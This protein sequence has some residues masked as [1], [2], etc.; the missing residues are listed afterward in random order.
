MNRSDQAVASQERNLRPPEDDAPPPRRLLIGWGT[1][2][3]ALA[4]S[5]AA[6]GFVLW[7][8]RFPIAQFFL[9]SALAERGVEAD[10][11][12]VQ[13]DFG[14]IVLNGVRIGSAQA[15]DASIATVTAAWD[16]RGLAPSVR[17]LR[18]VEP[19]LR[20]R[21]DNRGR[22]S[23]G[24][25]DHV[26]GAPSGHRPQVPELEV[27]VERGVLQVDA[28]FGPLVADVSA[29]GVLG[30]DFSALG[31]L[32][33]ITGARRNY[34]I[35]EGAGSFVVVSR[36]HEIGLRV[37]A[38]AQSLL[39]GD[40]RVSGLALRG[41]V[42]APLDLSRYEL[43][44]AWRVGALNSNALSADA[45]DGG[46]AF[47]A[48]ARDDSLLAS[49]WRARARAGA[50]RLTLGGASFTTARLDGGLDGR[51]MRGQGRWA[52]SGESFQGF[53]LI[54]ERATASGVLAVNLAGAGGADATGVIAMTRARLDPGARRIVDSMLPGLGGTPLAPT[55]A[56]ANAALRRGGANFALTAPF[57]AHFES[58]IQRIVFNRELFAHAASGLRLSVAPLRVDAPG[59][60]LEWPGA[61]LRGAVDVELSGGGA[62]TASMLLDTVHW[63]PGEPLEADGTLALSH[64]TAGDASLSADQLDI[65][66][67]IGTRGQGRIDLRGPAHITGPFGDGEVRDMAPNLDIGIAWDAGW[68]IV[69]NTPCLTVALGGLN[70]AGLS[71]DSG[72]L[73][74]CALNGALA[75]SDARG[76][77]GGGF[78]IQGLALNGRMAGP[79]AQPARLTAAE[80]T[81]R[82]HGAGA[83][84]ELSIEANRPALEINV[85]ADHVLALRGAQVTADAALAHDWRID[86]RF[87]DGALSDPALPG[88]VTAIAG[89]WAAAPEDDKAVIR[90]DAGEALLTANRP[91]SD[92][93]RPLFHQ[94][95]LAGFSAILRDGNIDAQGE[96]VL[97]EQTHQLARFTAHHDVAAGAGGAV[98]TGDSVT[99]DRT[100]QPYQISELARGFVDNVRGSV[101]LNANIDW[102]R[103]SIAAH[104]VL[105]LDGVSLAT[106]TIPVIQGVRGDVAFNNLFSLTT[107]PGQEITIDALNPGLVVHNGR[108]RFQLLPGRRIGI[109]R[110]EFDFASG[111]LS[112]T[113]TIIPIGAEETR[114]ELSL[115]NVDA[116]ALLATLNIPDLSATGK[117]DGA[118]PLLLTRRT[119]LIQNGALY[120]QRGG[121]TISY[122]G[123]A[124]DSATGAARI[125]FDALKS[126][127]YDDLHIA[128]NGDLSG[129][130]VSA[131]QFHGHNSGRPVDLGPIGAVPGL[132]HI[133][134][135]GVPFAFQVQVTA[136]FRSLAETAASLSNPNAI[137]TRA[138]NAEPA[139]QPVDQR[140]QG[141]R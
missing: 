11:Q 119:A 28:P 57:S 105:H 55:F 100:F 49:T 37:D 17:S 67:S 40:A 68:R 109:E 87:R 62:P 70:A 3:A 10:F 59:L 34:A 96:L 15:P 114:F 102:T 129:E 8:A 4:V 27:V 32:R 78:R 39:W 98:V 90:V 26:G 133:T 38:N 9:S 108:V 29:H 137:L 92:A 82:F 126:F 123:H 132:G 106:S 5:T 64:W 23:A 61:S 69:S 58:G 12:V 88:T 81:G 93:D 107:P 125:A 104:G 128:L 112:M 75:A 86:G 99:F 21:L 117:I 45:L 127:S 60:T 138:R 141:P 1:A 51:D 50:E 103:N 131:I 115:H 25:L 24:A 101:G 94:L 140:P 80:V 42:R 18:F 135:H 130:I 84:A 95:R 47:V 71:F 20:L 66:I 52:L 116:S 139:P 89:H 72:R 118:F 79:E 16:W 91:A 19:R 33:P 77:L 41:L 113:P 48:A 83:Q 6:L 44:A 43:D 122:V 65:G 46:A 110:A 22:L 85:A 7:L 53:S 36:A 63:S 74:L 56:Q 136:P 13:L 31:R 111:T 14:H 54:S 120:A 121:G 30:E 76:N 97:A 124:G 2:V 134:V 35:L 73:S